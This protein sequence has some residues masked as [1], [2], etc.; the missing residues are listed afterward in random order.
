VLILLQDFIRKLKKV[1]K[2]CRDAHTTKG[3]SSTTARS[4]SVAQPRRSDSSQG[5]DSDIDL[6]FLPDG[7]SELSGPQSFGVSSQSSSTPSADMAILQ[8][9]LHMAILQHS[10]QSHDVKSSG[11]FVPIPATLPFHHGPLSRA[12][13]N[14]IGKLGRWKRVLNSR[15]SI[16][17]DHSTPVNVSP[18]DLEPNVT[19]ELLSVRG[20]V[21][22]YLL[23][24]K[25]LGGH[26]QEL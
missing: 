23:T 15:Y 20:G 26:R 1:A 13:V 6:D 19:G 5:N 14:T 3:R 21:E 25:P 18:F 11:P 7:G 8:Q 2:E 9:P 12:F 24:R 10:K 17:P 16:H 4:S 22:Q